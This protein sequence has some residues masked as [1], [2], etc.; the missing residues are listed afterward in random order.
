MDHWW[1]SYIHYILQDLV[2]APV[3]FLLH[4]LLEHCPLLRQLEDVRVE[5]ECLSPKL[6]LHGPEV[7]TQ[8]VLPEDMEID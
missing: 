5:V 7:L 8:K 2:G 4:S 1:H 6:F 3:V